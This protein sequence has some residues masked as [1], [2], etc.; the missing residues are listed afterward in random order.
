[1]FVRRCR[2]AA[3]LSLLAALACQGCVHAGTGPMI[4]YSPSQ[5]LLVGWEGTAGLG[6][7]KVAAGGSLRPLGTSPASLYVAA[8]PA[9][10]VPVQ[11]FDRDSN[12]AT[13]GGT[14]GL[15]T[16]VGRGPGAVVG[17]WGGGTV[18]TND[19]NCSYDH[20]NWVSVVIGFRSFGIV[21]EPDER[22]WEIYASPKVG[23]VWDCPRLK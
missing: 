19:A 7:A 4:G 20:K 15:G 6:P 10:A 11:D 9:V 14:F 13:L 16:N 8:E 22:I 5:H 17:L 2:V 1:M 3:L 21:D 23:T 12:L 18:W